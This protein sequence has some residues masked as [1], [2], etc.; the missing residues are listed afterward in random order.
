MVQ[1]LIRRDFPSTH[2][3]ST[4]GEII[5]KCWHGEYATMANVERAIRSALPGCECERGA[6]VM[7]LEMYTAGVAGCQEFLPGEGKHPIT[8]YREKQA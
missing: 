3:D 7:E 2:A 1:A 6:S 4:S 8:S 5:S